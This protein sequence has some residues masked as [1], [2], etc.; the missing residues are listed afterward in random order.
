V[1]N[2]LTKTRK[3][4]V[5]TFF[6]SS[7]NRDIVML[8]IVSIAIGSSLASLVA[9][10][11]NSYFSETI[12]TL[13]GEYG[14]FDLLINVREEM[15]ENGNV[16]IEKV[17]EQVFPGGKLKEGPT[18]NGLT[19]FLVG[20]PAQYKT[21]QTYET[22]DSIFG[23]VPGRSGISIMTEPRITLRAVPDGAKST[24]IEQIMHI[25]G[26]LFAFRDG[27]SVTVIIQ[28]LDKSSY[29]NEEIKK[30][31]GQYHTIDIAF[32]VGGEPENSMRLGEQIANAIQE[33]KA[34]GYAQ[35]VSVDSKSNDMVYMVSSM[36]E[37]KRFLTAFATKAKITPVTGVSFIIGDSIAFQGTAPNALITGVPLDA[38]NI[39]VKVT[40][41]EG[42][43]SA[44]GMVIQGDGMQVASS[45]GYRV[46]NSV[47]GDP[48]GT[49]TF[50]NPR[51]EL[52]KALKE[53]GDLVL[54]IPK[55][56]QNAQN[57]AGVANN[58]LNNYSGSI[59]AVEQTLSSLASAGTT[60]QSATSGL[61]NL[62][63]SAI[64]LQLTNSSHAVGSLVN[65]LQIV[66]VLN[67]DVSSS[68]NE[69]TATQQNLTNLQNTLGALD[70]VAAD[71]RQARSAI[72]NIVVNG[73]SMVAN[74]RAFDVNG[75]RQTL[76]EAGTGITQLQQFNTPL[77]AAQ[78]QYLATAVPNLKDEEISRSIALMDQF[79]AGQVIPSQRIQIMTKSSITTEFAE[80]II[81]GVVGHNN[82]SLYTSAVGI[83]EPDPRG[84]VM[85]ILTQVKA[86]LAGMVSLIATI[87]FL[88]LDHTAVMTV[89]R[90]KRIVNKMPQAKGWKRM[91]QGIKNTFTVPECLYGMG[92]GAL[93]L[94]TT[95]VLSG[96]GIPYLPWIGVPFLGA[97]MGLLLAN[98]SEKISPI[99]VDEVTAGEALG[100]SFD[101]VMRE[102]V[103]PNGRPGLLQTLNRR[104]MKF[105]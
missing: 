22:M 56:A 13:V 100:L 4:F 5:R 42:D 73:N 31:L 24:I 90:R 75:A 23:S 16:Q 57:M 34:A 67:P 12:S 44:E 7:F 93:I 41:V 80:P 66:R 39:L 60:I 70:N 88:T 36:I 14:E 33:E 59:T 49:A 27:G 19:S 8:M 95:F 101:E 45:Q 62:D 85:V 15:K 69:L 25:D 21:K 20:L 72:D 48:V 71:A 96:G 103:I 9:M 43:G 52:G 91:L 102:I 87:I 30:L 28:S 58:A 74:L 89:I 68:V 3:T 50:Q 6:S 54:Q 55:I 29:V 65:T 105:K 83:I 40:A 104:K 11:A 37:M 99:S 18:L 10:S 86:I 79:I 1:A 78:L 64:Q 63:T 94:T 77:V 97:A 47:I 92:I 46:I 26:V 35:S 53:T 38:T 61:A 98:N 81:S 51:N 84:E 76:T 2:I 32:P 17:I 82:F